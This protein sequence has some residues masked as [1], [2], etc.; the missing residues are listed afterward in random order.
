MLRT[1]QFNLLKK[2]NN[3]MYFYKFNMNYMNKN[4]QMNILNFNLN[5]NMKINIHK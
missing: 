4:K 2:M 3:I 1:Q 5:K